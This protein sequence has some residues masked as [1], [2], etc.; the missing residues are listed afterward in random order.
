M[1]MFTHK[2]TI[3][4]LHSAQ[5]HKINLIDKHSSSIFILNMQVHYT[6]G[7]IAIANTSF[8]SAITHN[9]SSLHTEAI[10]MPSLVAESPW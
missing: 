4:S 8:Y 3:S 6:E 9:K 10:P 2:W 1:I 5:F 7:T